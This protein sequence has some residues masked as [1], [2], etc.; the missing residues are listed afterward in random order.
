VAESSALARAIAAHAWERHA[1][2]FRFVEP[3]IEDEV[4]LAE[5]LEEILETIT[6]RRLMRGRVAYFHSGTGTVVIVEPPSAGTAL[7]ASDPEGYY[8]RLR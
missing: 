4:E 8:E 5:F 2:D 1:D 3:R 7:V 6:P